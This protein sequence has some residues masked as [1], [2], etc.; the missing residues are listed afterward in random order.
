MENRRRYLLLIDALGS[1]GA[2]RQMTYLAIE[3]KKAGHAVKLITFYDSIDF[4]KDLLI[5]E[6]IEV[7]SRTDGQHFIKRPLVI[8][9]EILDFHPDM[10]IAFKDGVTIA[11]CIAKLMCKFQL[12]VSERNTTQSISIKDR[13]KFNL[14]RLADHIV[15]NSF[16]QS[17]FIARHFPYL[18]KK[19]T[20][21][22]NMID[23]TRFTP[24]K[25]KQEHSP[26]RVITTA[27]VLPQKNIHNYIEAISI[28]KKK[29][30]NLS[31]NWYGDK[32]K[33]FEDFNKSITIHIE[34]LNLE[35]TVHFFEAKQN[36]EAE[37]YN[38]DIFLLPSLYEGFPNVLCEAMSCGLPC[39]TTAV[40]DSPLILPD[41]RFHANPNSPESIAEA[42]QH[43]IELSPEERSKIGKA[44]AERIK[45]LCSPKAFIDKYTALT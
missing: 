39:V 19:V 22:T 12:I 4:Y 24:Q 25:H 21:I 2:E 6:N 7:K 15:P 8:R 14:Y 20:V 37:Y 23:T 18:M 1:G 13:L 29:G 33:G 17:D 26:L 9:N 44:N 35:K 16:S 40:C 10:V 42:I 28:L 32:F 27:R 45:E 36:I 30:Y 38:H 31:F 34:Q 3:L 41:S 5:K 11:S 43:I